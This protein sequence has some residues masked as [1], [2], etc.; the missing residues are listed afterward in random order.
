MVRVCNKK[1]ERKCNLSPEEK[2]QVRVVQECRDYYE[3]VC[4]TRYVNKNI[5][6]DKVTCNTIMT[7]MCDDLGENCAQFPQT[8][9]KLFGLFDFLPIDRYR[10]IGRL[11]L[12]C[13]FEF[14]RQIPSDKK[15]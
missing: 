7:E 14:S 11:S 8:V 4:Q 6:E 12:Y 9:S 13:N 15:L 3:S 10:L 5:T 2:A 1:P